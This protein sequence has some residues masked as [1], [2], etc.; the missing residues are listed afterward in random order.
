MK[1]VRNNVLLCLGSLAVMSVFLYLG[2]S[3]G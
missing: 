3:G 1:E 2:F